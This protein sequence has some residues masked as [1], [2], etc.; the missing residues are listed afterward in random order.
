MAPEP[1]GDVGRQI[2]GV[3]SALRPDARVEL[4]AWGGEHLVRGRRVLDVGCGDGRFAL[5]VAALAKSVSGLDP[6]AESIAAARR[7]A[8]TS[9]IR[10]VEFRVGAAQELGYRA[11]SFDVVILSWSL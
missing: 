4:H 6:D 9:G 3:S 1:I 2:P 11:G 5:G 7:S 8:R 10:N